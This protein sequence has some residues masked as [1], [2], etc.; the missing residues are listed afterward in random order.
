MLASGIVGNGGRVDFWRQSQSLAEQRR[1]ESGPLRLKVESL[2][3]MPVLD[4]ELKAGY[5]YGL[6]VSVRMEGETAPLAPG[7]IWAL[8]VKSARLE[9]TKGLHLARVLNISAPLIFAPG[10]KLPVADVLTR[11]DNN[12]KD[13]DIKGQS[14]GVWVYCHSASAKP[15]LNFQIEAVAGRLSAPAGKWGRQKFIATGPR[16]SAPWETLA[17]QPWNAADDAANVAK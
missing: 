13:A 16:C 15:Q 6:R 1:R 12:I 10:D 9:A 8:R 2:R 14:A 11:T 7:Q 17:L 4:E 5:N 3:F